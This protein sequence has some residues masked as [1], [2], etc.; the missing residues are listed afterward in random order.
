MTLAHLTMVLKLMRPSK[1]SNRRHC[2]RTSQPCLDR[3]RASSSRCR[4]L[5]LVLGPAPFLQ[6]L[7]VRQLPQALSS[8]S[9]LSRLPPQA[10]V[11]MFNKHNDFPRTLTL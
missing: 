2:S 5:A 6:R 9:R 1:I 7:R 11:P 10:V 4:Y 3:V 8:L